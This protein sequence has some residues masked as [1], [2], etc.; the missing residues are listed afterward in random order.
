MR[1]GYIKEYHHAADSMAQN[2]QGKHYRKGIGI[3]DVIRMS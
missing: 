1:H 3:A 2:T